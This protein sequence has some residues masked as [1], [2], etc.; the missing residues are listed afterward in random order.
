MQIHHVWSKQRSSYQVVE[1]QGPGE[2]D[3]E[4]HG[5][6]RETPAGTLA[7]TVPISYTIYTKVYGH[8]FWSCSVCHIQGN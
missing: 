8:P 6:L 7:Y 5:V 3:D 2:S 4:G 1:S